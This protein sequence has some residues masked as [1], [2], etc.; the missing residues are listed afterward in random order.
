MDRFEDKYEALL[1]EYNV[2]K[3]E[4]SVDAHGAEKVYDVVVFMN[5]GRIFEGSG[6]RPLAALKDAVI[7]QVLGEREFRTL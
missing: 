2:E 1:E 3:I 6:P 7:D 5:D 4:L